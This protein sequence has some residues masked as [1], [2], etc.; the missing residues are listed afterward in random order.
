MWSIEGP[1][2]VDGTEDAGHGFREGASVRYDSLYTRRRRA[3]N[4]AVLNGTLCF[5]LHT[6]FLRIHE[7]RG[8]F[9]EIRQNR[10]NPRKNVLH[11]SLGLVVKFP[12]GVRPA[13]RRNNAVKLFLALHQTSGL[14]LDNVDDKRMR[15]STDRC[16]HE[17]NVHGT[18]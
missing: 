11:V 6:L 9:A 5:L 7:G 4:R 13:G 2:V 3:Y 17:F 15:I 1:L 14:P 10:R 16:E 18:T 12:C 8:I